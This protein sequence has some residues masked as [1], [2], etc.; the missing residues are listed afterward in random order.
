MMW[1]FD[2]GDGFNRSRDLLAEAERERFLRSV[3]ASAP[4]STISR[5]MQVRQRVGHALIRRGEELAGNGAGRS[6]RL[7]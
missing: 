7:S 2:S 5:R 6:V 3:Q 4:Q 1:L